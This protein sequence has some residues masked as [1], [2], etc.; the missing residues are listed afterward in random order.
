[1][2]S[3]QLY[4]NYY[5]FYIIRCCEYCISSYSVKRFLVWL[6]DFL[7]CLLFENPVDLQMSQIF[8]DWAYTIH[9]VECYIYLKFWQEFYITFKVPF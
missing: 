4:H 7:F 5:Y 1:M 8:T 2:P 9:N 6:I 3:Q